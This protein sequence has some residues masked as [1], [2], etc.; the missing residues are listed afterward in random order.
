MSS[1]LYILA[2][3]IQPGMIFGA[4]VFALWT[5][6][7]IL[8]KGSKPP[9]TSKPSREATELA[10]IRRRMLEEQARQKQASLR[11]ATTL[12][13][14]AAVAKQNVQQRIA[15][16]QAVRQQNRQVATP[17]VRQQAAPRPAVVS[18]PTPP[19]LPAAQRFRPAPAPRTAPQ[20]VRMDAPLVSPS[21]RTRSET[22][23]NVRLLVQR[24]AAA[25]A[26]ILAEIFGTP[27]GLQ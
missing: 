22:V 17:P 24:G 4:I 3:G 11:T 6:G 16:Q 1:S 23:K 18:T 14:Q 13:A 20:P 26:F 15:Q 10:A 9:T 19:R 5:L 12:R 21:S 7:A 8:N 27:K 2:D 25:E